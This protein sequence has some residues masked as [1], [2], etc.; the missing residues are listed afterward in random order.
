MVKVE[1]HIVSE[2]SHNSQF[3]ES[4]VHEIFGESLFGSEFGVNSL[5][6]Q[7][8]D[9]VGD[10]ILLSADADQFRVEIHVGHSFESDLVGVGLNVDFTLNEF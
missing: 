7:Q 3:V 6:F 1:V 9:Q 5:F 8:R 10:G 2:G 4:S